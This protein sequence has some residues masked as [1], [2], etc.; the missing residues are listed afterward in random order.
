MSQNQI[1]PVLTVGYI[2]KE[3]SHTGPVAGEGFN[4][5]AR[6]ML[7]IA[8]MD[9]ILLLEPF[10]L[11]QR[12]LDSMTA[13]DKQ[14]AIKT[15]F[16]NGDITPL[17]LFPPLIENTVNPVSEVEPFGTVWHNT[18]AST[19]FTTDGSGDWIQL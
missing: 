8:D 1:S 12:R 13:H 9:R 17:N 7:S 10:S 19:I 4:G 14:F 5:L 2:D 15:A 18:V 3:R 11:T 6:F 16:D